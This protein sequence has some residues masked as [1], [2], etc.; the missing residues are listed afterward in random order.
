MALAFTGRSSD[1]SDIDAAL[2]EVMSPEGLDGKP[3]VAFVF[4]STH[5]FPSAA[6]IAGD[7]A[8]RTGARHVLGCGGGGIIGSRR[9]L[10]SCPALS[11]L[12]ARLPGSKI[13]PF[14]LEDEDEITSEA[15]VERVGAAPSESP[16][17]VVLPD[18]YSVD[19]VRLIDRFN[20]AYPGAVLCGGLASGAETPGGNVLLLDG[21]VYTSGAVGLSFA[22][23]VRLRAVVSQGCRPVG[24][25]FVVTRAE[26]NVIHELSGKPAIEG[27]R[28][29]WNGLEG[30]DRELAKEMLFVGRVTSEQ[31]A[32][33]HRGDFLIR[34][35]MG[36]DKRSGAIA[37]GDHV[38]RGMTVQ[39]QV[40]D[41]E[42]ALEDLHENL[43][44]YKVAEKGSPRGALLFSCLGRGAGMYGTPN[45]DV[46]SV[47]EVLGEMPKAGFFCNGE[48]GPIGDSNFV[49]GFTLSS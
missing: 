27:V 21:A 1:R 11:V 41:G 4:L 6:R 38:R 7:V 5:F 25:R 40:R 45:R 20:T 9:E 26:N 48:I 33:F 18:P 46:L 23:S 10:E 15:F 29:V 31:K 13:R 24:R 28:E 49:H 43:E 32:E 17:F 22:G 34:N 35:L 16:G 44:R 8:E 37:V 36:I 47:D 30:K 3:D 14:R 12:F 19:V 2:D 42:T 39:F